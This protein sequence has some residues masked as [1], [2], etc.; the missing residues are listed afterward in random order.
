[1]MPTLDVIMSPK[2]AKAGCVALKFSYQGDYLAISFNNE[3]V[4]DD[5]LTKGMEETKAD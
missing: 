1:M 5:L 4:E 2:E 3:A